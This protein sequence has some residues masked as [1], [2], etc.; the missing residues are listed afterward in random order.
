MAKLTEVILNNYGEGSSIEYKCLDES[1][2][3][4]EFALCP[5][6][7]KGRLVKLYIYPKQQKNMKHFYSVEMDCDSINLM[8]WTYKNKK[9]PWAWMYV[10]CKEHKCMSIQVYVPPNTSKLTISALSGLNIYFD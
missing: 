6:W 9:L 1:Y 3:R 5:I 8:S 4:A 10:W 2:G 7:K